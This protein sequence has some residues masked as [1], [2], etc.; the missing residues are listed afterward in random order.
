MG[1]QLNVNVARIAGVLVLDGLQCSRRAA[2]AKQLIVQLQ[3]VVAHIEARD[4]HIARRS[5]ELE[6]KYVV[7]GRGGE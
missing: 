4:G 5:I 7:A 6:G 2:K 1:I 3:H